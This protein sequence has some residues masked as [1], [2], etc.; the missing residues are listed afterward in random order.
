MDEFASVV[1]DPSQPL[2]LLQLLNAFDALD[3]TQVE[4]GCY[5]LNHHDFASLDVPNKFLNCLLCHLS[6]ALRFHCNQPLPTFELVLLLLLLI[7]LNL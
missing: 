7:T 6:N 4:L 5:V 2:L 1:G 3:S